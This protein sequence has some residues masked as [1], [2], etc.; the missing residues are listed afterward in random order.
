MPVTSD[1]PLLPA[2][3]TARQAVASLRGYAYQTIVA[4][5][6]WVDLQHHDRIYLEV[7]EDYAVV[8]TGAIQA[9]QV[10]D[11]AQSAAI[12]SNSEEVIK[13]IASFVDLVAKN[14]EI[15]HLH[16]FT[17][18]EIGAERAL[19]DR[20][21]SLPV[22]EYWR[23]AAAGA[24]ISP[25]RSL[26]VSDR[27]PQSVNEFVSAKS[28]NELREKLLS[29]IHWDCGRPD[30]TDLYEE[31]RQRLI[32][33]G[34][35]TFKLPSIES[36][37]LAEIL[38]YKVLQKSVLPQPAERVLTRADLY[39]VIDHATSVSLTRAAVEQ[40][41]ALTG[42]L[43]SGLPGS[44][45]SISPSGPE[46]EWII[47]GAT[48][49][50][51]DGHIPRVT[52]EKDLSSAIVEY[53]AS[54]LIGPT[55]VGKSA[56]SRTVG[57]SRGDYVLVDFRDADEREVIS[58]LN[59]LW[60][61]VGGLPCRT[62]IFEDLN[63]W[64]ARVA[65][66][67]GR[68]LSALR[69]RDILSIVTTYSSPDRRSLTLSGIDPAGTVE[70]P[71]FSQ[72]QTSRLVERHGGDR[73]PWG[74][75]AYLASGG[76]HPQLA[77]AF[78]LGMKA[79][80][81]PES[82]L[83]EVVGQGISSEDIDAEREGA[84]RNLI[85]A[86]PVNA[87]TLLYRLSLVVG[88]F[89]RSL[90]LN[91]A[92]APPPIISAGEGLDA[93]VGSW[94]EPGE[95]GQFRVSPLAARLGVDM[96][97]DGEQRA[98]HHTI[99]EQMVMGGSIQVQQAGTI[100]LHA[101]AGKNDAVLF[102][103]ARTVIL[104]DEVTLGHLAENMFAFRYIA[105]NADVYPENDLVGVLLRMA[106]VKV[107]LASDSG[108]E[109][110]DHYVTALLGA[111]DKLSIKAIRAP[112]RVMALLMVLVTM[113][114]ANKL[115]GWLEL[116]QQFDEAIS[117]AGEGDKDFLAAIKIGGMPDPV[118]ALFAIGTAKLA[119]VRRL[120]DLI[121]E[122]SQMREERRSVFLQALTE[123]TPD[124]SVLAHSPWLQQHHASTLDPEEARLLY[125]SMAEKTEDWPERNLV[126]Q[127]WIAQAI[128]SDEFKSDPGAAIEALD[129]AGSKFGN[130]VLLLRARAKVLSR[131]GDHV[132]ALD[133]M[134]EIAAEVGADNVVERAF[135]LREAA[136][137]AAK[138]GDWR[139]AREWFLL[140][141]D[142]ARSSEL[143]DMTVMSA[144]LLGDAAAASVKDGAMREAL[145]LL[146]QALDALN[147]IEPHSSLVAEHCH[148]LIRHTVL[149][150]LSQVDGTAPLIGGEPIAM[151]A[152]SCS[153]PEPDKRIKDQ[154]LGPIDYARYMLAQAEVSSGLQLGIA[155]ALSSKLSGGPI[156]LMEIELR[157]RRTSYAIREGLPE[158]FVDSLWPYVE[159]VS[160]TIYN[161]DELRATDVMN[162]GRGEVSKLPFSA[163]PQRVVRQTARDALFSFA[164]AAVCDEFPAAIQFLVEHL[165]P[166]IREAVAFTIGGAVLP[167]SGVKASAKT[168]EE[169]LAGD[170]ANLLS[171]TATPLHYATA[172]VRFMQHLQVSNF[173]NV[174]LPKV[175]SWHQRVWR[176]II[177]NQ[178]F[179]LP[180][181][182]LTV[183]VLLQALDTA[184][185]DSLSLARITLG[186]ADVMDLY[187]PGEM[188]AA[189]AKG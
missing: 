167:G 150:V 18:S 135:A 32:V 54:L 39:S 178:Q 155:S 51:T 144:G 111:V 124:F 48:V 175:H 41:T 35:D 31:L 40:I 172:G 90:A 68:A 85:A 117:T 67:L 38:A 4:A 162:A 189:L 12:T 22:L 182:R 66:M 109:P 123:E 61:R 89:S 42:Q 122:L 87:R 98:I 26:L 16:Y 166:A 83:T 92:A 76:G 6:A 77:Q 102:G 24:D 63:V 80:G 180:S 20:I 186:A 50:I 146:D 131:A 148:R 105:T 133:I 160:E 28:D 29:R 9:F 21:D 168:F 179:L 82:A 115:K 14:G 134:R 45:L 84:R 5:I 156:I 58:R 60:A 129:E 53:G 37:R 23:R 19:A 11:T 44:P 139:R 78:I 86:L 81:W 153:N 2:G 177:S 110:L 56:V 57:L 120:A 10:K 101:L 49:P 79:K 47:A 136:I 170:I 113:G 64:T 71:Y 69:R 96:L 13:A 1:D 93:L 52:V 103:L 33:V 169:Q 132:G 99:A 65:T 112:M 119:T 176:R 152:G 15:V 95:Q 183:P 138:T 62:V 8:A 55:G 158:L 106:Q 34:R 72:E 173:K 94:L 164:I 130:H 107:V 73:A 174:L 74:K 104:A 70:C 27:F 128:M 151:V 36:G 17:T 91:I 163:L 143:P 154:P 145:L 3:D 140:A 149:W 185:S 46:P 181:P 159:A 121:L 142:A 97:S 126:L 157:D 137:S 100:L 165:D 116:L 141:S 118:P 161:S 43:A 127:F 108:V 59:I 184:T 25:L 187:I 188:R 147:D 171:G 7:A 30:I 88:R 75:L 125:R 114:V